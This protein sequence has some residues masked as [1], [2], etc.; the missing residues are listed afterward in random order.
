ML[1]RAQHLHRLGEGGDDLIVDAA[2]D[3]QPR[4]GRA[5]LAGVDGEGP[6]GDRDRVLEGSASAKMMFGDLP[7]SSS[8]TGMSFSAAIAATRPPVTTEPVNAIL[9]TAGWRT[10]GAPTRGPVPVTMFTSPSGSPASLAISPSS[11]VVVDVNSEGFT[12]MALPAASAG[13][14]PAPP[15]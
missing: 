8:V 10:S 14:P 7:P 1:G 9:R 13:Q 5:G 12:T 4:P 11:K 2:I 3:D 15:G 6:H